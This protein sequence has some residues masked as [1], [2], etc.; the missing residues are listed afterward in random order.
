[1]EYRQMH[2]DE[3]HR[4]GELD[5]REVIDHI[6]YFR[7]GKLE[8]EKEHW[9]IP[10]WTEEQKQEYHQR[11]QN[12]HQRGGT[13]IG[14]F[15]DTKITGIIALDHEFFGSNLDRLNL[16][17]LWASQPFRDRGVGRHLVELVKKKAKALDAKSLYVS[18]TPSKKTVEFYMSCGFQLAKII[19]S[20]LFELEPEDIH[21]EFKL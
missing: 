17:A 8:L 12:I 1:M 9:D 10:E 15:E 21:M 11:L 13:I 16:A 4:V 5:R 2:K 6:Y 7:D 20:K 3:L 18:A 14:A 19:D